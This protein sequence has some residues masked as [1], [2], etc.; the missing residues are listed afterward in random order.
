MGAP[1]A[2]CGYV[3][4]G[5]PRRQATPRTAAR[6]WALQALL[7]LSG[8]DGVQVADRAAE[9]RHRRLR[10]EWADA[11]VVRRPTRLPHRVVEV[12]EGAAAAARNAQHGR[13]L[14]V[15]ISDVHEE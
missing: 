2:R 5:A 13:D 7:N 4:Q 3:W 8:D 1:T 11:L 6:R 12:G 15:A 14:V 10:R 9:E